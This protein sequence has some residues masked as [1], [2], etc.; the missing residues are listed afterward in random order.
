MPGC[1][2]SP[3]RAPP[4]SAS[5]TARLEQLGLVLQVE[6]IAQHH[7]ERQDRGERVGRRPCR[8][9]RARCRGPARRAPCA[10]RSHRPRRARPRAACRASPSASPRNRTSMSPNR[11]SV[12]MTSNCLG[13]RTSCMAQLSAYMCESATSGIFRVVQLLHFLAPQHARFHDVRLLDRAQAPLALARRARR[14]RA[15]TRRISGVV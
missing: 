5:T 6:G 11:L 14:R 15:A 10:G 4:S 1:K 3:V 12:T 13:L 2:M 7:G 9:C 8:R